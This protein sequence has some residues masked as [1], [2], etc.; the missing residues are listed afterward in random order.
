MNILGQK[1]HSHS[2]TALFGK[3]DGSSLA[4]I[5]QE[6]VG[7]LKEDARS[8]SCRQISSYSTPVDEV[9]NDPDAAVD[10]VV[11]PRSVDMNNKAYTASVVLVLSAVKALRRL[12]RFFLLVI[13]AVH[14]LRVPGW[15]VRQPISKG[16]PGHRSMPGRPISKGYG[17]GMNPVKT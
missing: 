1:E 6:T 8:V 5:S 3:P 2:V 7:D 14:G 16:L 9:L 17:V 10:Y 11:G 12:R 4:L 15:M 13:G